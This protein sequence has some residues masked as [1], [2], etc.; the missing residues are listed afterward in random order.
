MSVVITST[1]N[2]ILY[3][4]PSQ[5]HVIAHAIKF[6]FVRFQ[7]TKKECKEVKKFFKLLRLCKNLRNIKQ[8]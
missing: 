1:V 3:F 7:E 6:I 5:R 4:N 8:T 2:I